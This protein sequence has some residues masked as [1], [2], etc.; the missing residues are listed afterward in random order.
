MSLYDRIASSEAGSR[1][2]ADAR[3]RREVLELIHSALE[4]CGLTQVEIAKRLGVRK[5]AVNQVL[6]GDGNVRITTLAEYLYATGHEMTVGLVPAGQPRRA[7]LE[8]RAKLGVTPLEPYPAAE[9]PTPVGFHFE[10]FWSVDHS[11]GMRDARSDSKRGP[12]EVSVP[13]R[14]RQFHTETPGK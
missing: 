5:S 12:R 14:W 8:R 2:L 10:E 7:V 13:S 4:E 9:P 1:A 3:L 11:V 6:R